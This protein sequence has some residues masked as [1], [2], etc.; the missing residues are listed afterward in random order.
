MF[1]RWLG[2][3]LLYCEKRFRRVK[4]LA[5]LAQVIATIETEH[6]EKQPPSRTK[7]A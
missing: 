2:T 1:E 6:A 3:V 7:A 4:D 5:G